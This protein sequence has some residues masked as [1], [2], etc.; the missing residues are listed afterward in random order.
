ML[1]Y[2]YFFYPNAGFSLLGHFIGLFEVFFTQV[3]SP[4]PPQMLGS[5][6]WVILFVYFNSG[7]FFF[8]T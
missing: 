7:L 1:G 4:P 5:D 6:C 8:S 2:V 3:L